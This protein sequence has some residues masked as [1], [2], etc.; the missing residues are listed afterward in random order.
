MT[1]TPM[2][3]ISFQ[4]TCNMESV[5]SL[6]SNA[7]NVSSSAQKLLRRYTKKLDVDAPSFIGENDTVS[8]EYESQTPLLPIVT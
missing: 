5:Q 1:I 3:N 8:S 2:A 6:G 7:L 4:Q